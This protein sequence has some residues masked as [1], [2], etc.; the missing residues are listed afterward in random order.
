MSTSTTTDW[1]GAIAGLVGAAT[2][3]V[4]LVLTSRDKSRE[5]ATARLT[6]INNILIRHRMSRSHWG[7]L[8]PTGG[9]IAKIE[10]SLAGWRQLLEK[11]ERKL[12]PESPEGQIIEQLYRKAADFLYKLEM[13]KSKRDPPYDRITDQDPD[14]GGPW[15]N[16]REETD[17]LSEQL[18]RLT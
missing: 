8:E 6:A 2:G 15:Q 1:V 12:G 17:H 3:T 5:R 9:S 13:A 10:E 16:F 18:A 4:A 7:Y 11:Q 14:V